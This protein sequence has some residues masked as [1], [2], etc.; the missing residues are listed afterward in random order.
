VTIGQ[1]EGHMVAGEAGRARAGSG[2]LGQRVRDARELRAPRHPVG[3]AVVD[4]HHPA[5]RGRE[6]RLTE[7]EEPVHRLR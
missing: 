1:L 6:D 2:R 7:R 5:G 3:L 4:R